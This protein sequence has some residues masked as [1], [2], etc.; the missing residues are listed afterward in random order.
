MKKPG[1]ILGA[2][3]EQT[4][5]GACSTMSLSF[6]QFNLCISWRFGKGLV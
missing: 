6:E 1:E 5:M 3:G 2:L 4:A